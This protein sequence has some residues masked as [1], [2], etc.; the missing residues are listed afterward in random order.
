[1]VIGTGTSTFPF[2]YQL[3][4]KRKPSYQVFLLT[5]NRQLTT[6]N[7]YHTKGLWIKKF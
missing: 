2:S 6:D 5:D 1:M 4:V 7:Y 3:S